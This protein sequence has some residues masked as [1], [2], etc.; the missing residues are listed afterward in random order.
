M[1][2]SLVRR[3]TEN[4]AIRAAARSSRSLPPVPAL[5]AALLDAHQRGDREGVTLAAHRAVRAAEPGVG[6]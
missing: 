6:E 4:A 1:S 3:P 5:M 2:R